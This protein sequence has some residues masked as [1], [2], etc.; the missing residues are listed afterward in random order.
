M[1]VMNNSPQMSVIVVTPDCFETV[2]KS[3]RCLRAQNNAHRLEIILVA[4]SVA[5]IAVD[6]DEMRNFYSFRTIEVGQMLSTARARAAGVRAA[7]AAIVAFVE[8]HAFP[9]P[10]WAEALIEA[11]EQDWAAVGP[12]MGNANPNALTSWINLAVEYSYW[13]EPMRGGEVDHLPGHNCSYKRETILGYGERLEQMMDA[14]SVLHWDLRVK[15]HRLCVEPRA[16]TLHQN[17]SKIIPSL[18]LR[19]HGGRLF[20]SAR[21]RDWPIWRSLL[22]TAASPLIP[23]VRIVRIARELRR[24]GRPRH[25]LPRI[26]PGLA[27]FL[28]FDGLGEMVGYA[29]GA[30]RSMAILSEME[31]HRQRYLRKADRFEPA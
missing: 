12:V 21:A 13:L 18:T 8:D 15:G 5:E 22:F 6:E 9:G 7:S 2:R 23:L 25:L 17:F 11:H 4:P 19:F 1:D 27:L 31:F 29:F 10:G 30:G 16:R 20:A 28:G 26:L 3:I 14:E 24:E